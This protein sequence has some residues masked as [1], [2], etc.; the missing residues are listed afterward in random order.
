MT[1]HHRRASNPSAFFGTGFIHG[2][3][4]TFLLAGLLHSHRT[5]L[6]P[7]Q[8]LFIVTFAGL[9]VTNYTVI[10]PGI[11]WYP[12]PGLAD[13]ERRLRRGRLRRLRT[14]PPP[15]SSSPPPVPVARAPKA[16]DFPRC[17]RNPKLLACRHADSLSTD[18]GLGGPPRDRILRPPRRRTVASQPA[19]Q[20]RPHRGRRSGLR[21]LGCYG[22]T[23]IQTPNLD[24]LAAEGMW[25]RS[26]VCGNT[27]CAPAAAP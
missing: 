14:R 22:Q 9:A 1:I 4:T 13:P 23:R 27:V 19:S 11:Y 20:H 8:R 21:D 24:Q 2:W 7:G 17:D 18:R 10:R 12:T 26:G 3:V 15:P 16:W 25:F 6:L 5:P